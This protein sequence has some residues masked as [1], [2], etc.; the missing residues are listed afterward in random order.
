MDEHSDIGKSLIAIGKELEKNLDNWEAWAA[1]ADILFS[2]GIFE[3]AIRCCDRSL[4]IKPDNALTWIT[5]GKALEKIGKCEDAKSAFAKAKD[6]GY[7]GPS[8]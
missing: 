8:D 4:A 1:K 7:C 3:V 5:K 2:M 6:L